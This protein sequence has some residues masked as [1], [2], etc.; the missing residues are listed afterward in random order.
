MEITKEQVQEYIH[1]N[2]YSFFV[3]ALAK[4]VRDIMCKGA[5][6]EDMKDLKTELKDLIFDAISYGVKNYLN[7][8]ENEAIQIISDKFLERFSDKEITI[9]FN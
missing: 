3:E 1:K 7:D 8:H 5:T 6:E 4:Y 9:S 2:F